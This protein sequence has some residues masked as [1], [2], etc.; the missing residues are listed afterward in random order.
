MLFNIDIEIFYLWL[1]LKYFYI[2]YYMPSKYKMNTYHITSV[3][4]LLHHIK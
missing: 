2:K 1:L 4:L 3:I